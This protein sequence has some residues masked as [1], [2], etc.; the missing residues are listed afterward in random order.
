MASP[1]RPWLPRRGPAPR[2][3]YPGVVEPVEPWRIGCT[4]SGEHPGRPTVTRFD[5]LDVGGV[6]R[7]DGYVV[8]DGALPCGTSVPSTMAEATDPGWSVTT[9][10][11][12]DP[13][14][15]PPR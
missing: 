3:A 2:G 12:D 1:A 15:M 10:G 6:T 5:F 13:V 8:Q 4:W 11:V 7:S 14:R 9:G